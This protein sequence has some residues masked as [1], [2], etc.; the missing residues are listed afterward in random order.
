LKYWFS[1]LPDGRRGFNTTYTIQDAALSAFSVFFTQC[2]SFLAY[3]TQMQET[4]GQNNATSLFQVSNIPS[5]NQTRNLLDPVASAN[6][7]PIYQHVYE[8]YWMQECWLDTIAS[9]KPY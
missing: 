6:L 3:Q 9:I 8:S 2:P 4:N 7:N 5:D 1:I